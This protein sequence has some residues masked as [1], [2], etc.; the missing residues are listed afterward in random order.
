YGLYTAVVYLTPF[1]GGIIAD[2]WL[3][4]R[5]SVFIG[6]A[7]MAVGEFM[8]MKDALFFPALCVLCVG[9]GMLKS[10]VSTHVGALYA[11]GDER[12]DRA[13]NV[14]YVGINLGAWIAPFICGTLGQSKDA[15]GN[16]HWAWGFGAA[17][18][19]MI[20]GLLIYAWGQKYLAPDQIMAKA[21]A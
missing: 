10:N 2:R 18:V 11:K 7:I 3:G 8:M 4:Q 13:F 5:K 14:F 21:H 19:G 16:E 6:G 9:C 15:A 12:R 20:I 1:F 17:G